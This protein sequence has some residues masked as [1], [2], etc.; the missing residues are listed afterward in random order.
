M[1]EKLEYIVILEFK[2]LIFEQ[3]SIVE[4]SQTKIKINKI[5]VF[6]KLKLYFIFIQNT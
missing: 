1:Q 3:S 4:Y 5:P 6:S 2:K